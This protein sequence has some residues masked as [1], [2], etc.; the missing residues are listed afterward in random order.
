M[1]SLLK[2]LGLDPIITTLSSFAGKVIEQVFSL[3]FQRTW[4]K[5]IIWNH[6]NQDSVLRKLWL[7]LLMISGATKVEVGNPS[8]FSLSYQQPSILLTAVS[9]QTCSWKLK[10]ELFYSSSLPP[11]PRGI[12]RGDELSPKPLYY[13]VSQVSTL[14]PSPA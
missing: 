6:I 13:G 12:G 4:R 2:R 14:L 10:I 5:K 7:H 8:M 9:F 11:F 3:Q 1:C